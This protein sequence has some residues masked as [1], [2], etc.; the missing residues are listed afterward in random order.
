MFQQDRQNLFYKNVFEILLLTSIYDN[1]KTLQIVTHLT[2]VRCT[3]QLFKYDW[4]WRPTPTKFYIFRNMSGESLW[5]IAKVTDTV[6]HPFVS[7]WFSKFL[8]K[9]RKYMKKRR[10]PC[11]WWTHDG[12]QLSWLKIT[13]YAFQNCLLSC[14][15]K[16]QNNQSD[17]WSSV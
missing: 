15:R 4:E 1:Q 13:R 3:R 8:H 17:H 16:N 2:G 6:T 11:T 9:S 7:T 5:I 10:F 12:C 14:K